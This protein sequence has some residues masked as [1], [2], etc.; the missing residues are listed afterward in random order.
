MT[1]WNNLFKEALKWRVEEEP[2]FSDPLQIG[3]CFAGDA[4]AARRVF[5]DAFGPLVVLTIYNP[6]YTSQST[7]IL[8]SLQD[9]FGSS[10]FVLGKIR[11]VDGGFTYIDPFG[12]LGRSWVAK[13]D[14]CFFEVRADD[15]NDFG[16]FPDARPARQA[17]RSLLTSDSVVLNLFSYTC[18]F[19]VIAKKAGASSVI[20]ID[21]NSEMLTWGKRNATL[22]NVDF[23]VVP[24]FAQKYLNRLQRRIEDGKMKCPDVWVCDP[25]AF[26]MGRGQQRLLKYFWDDFWKAV[27]ALRPRTVLVLRNDRTGFR[28][29][30]TLGEELPA[31]VKALYRIRAVDFAQTP[32]LCYDAHDAFYKLTESLVLFRS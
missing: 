4:D 1:N 23:A 26:G 3:R 17:L 25:P 18:G 21:A 24:E 7:L 2:R 12:V 32:S 28:A 15:K 22:N 30:E 20:N 29:G 10:R 5:V 9:F 16:L 11:K 8:N 27:E 31:F 19:G 6:D 13:E 14:D